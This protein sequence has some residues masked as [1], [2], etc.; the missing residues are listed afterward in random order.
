M[1]RGMLF[2]PL[3]SVFR[4]DRLQIGRHAA[5]GDRGVI[6]V[7]DSFKIFY[8]GMYDFIR[9]L[10]GNGLQAMDLIAERCYLL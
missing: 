10:H 2:E 7:D 8:H 4:R 3:N 6:D 1:V 5:A 9:L